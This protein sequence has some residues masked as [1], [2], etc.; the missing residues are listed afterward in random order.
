[1]NNTARH[2]SV[3]YAFIERQ[4][5]LYRRYWLWEVA[6][7]TWSLM[8]AL[9]IGFLG[10]GIEQVT[11]I[12]IDQAFYVTYLLVGAVVWSYLAV[13]YWEISAIVMIERWEGTLEYTFMAPIS[14]ATHLLGICLFALL[15]GIARTAVLLIIIGLFFHLTLAAPQLLMAAVV[16]ALASVSFVGLGMMVA[17]VPMLAPERGEQMAEIVFATLLTLSGVYYPITVLPGFLQVIARLSPAT[18][19]LQGIRKALGV[20][21]G[22]GTLTSDLLILA[23]LGVILVPLGAMVFSWAERYAKRRGTLARSG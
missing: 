8:G 11:G 6:W 15:Y 7:F 23:V 21:P 12:Q 22:G 2:A 5:M 9:S 17:V 13:I 19:T 10:K 14:R 3:I 4:L 20:W 16:M 18:Y 1:M